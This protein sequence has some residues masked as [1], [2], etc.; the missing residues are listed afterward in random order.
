MI[1]K[2]VI[3]GY[4]GHAFVIIDMLLSNNY[5]LEGYYDTSLQK[6]NPFNLPYLGKDDAATLDK[7]YH[8]FVCIGNNLIRASIFQKLKERDISYPPLFHKHSSTSNYATVGNGTV[9]MAGA[10]IN[11]LA[12]VGEGVICNTSSVIEHECVINNYAH[13]APGAVLAGNVEVGERSFIG[14]N[15]VIRQGIVIGSDVVIGAGAV[16]VKHVA[17]GSTVYGNPALAQIK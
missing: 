17:N 12:K 13:I 15:A 9:V 2:G 6:N 1:N 11:P 3:F 4:S 8:A 7:N 5:V 14:A 16:V 10:V